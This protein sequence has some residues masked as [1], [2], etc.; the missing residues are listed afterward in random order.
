MALPAGAVPVLL[1]VRF[2]SVGFVLAWGQSPSLLPLVPVSACSLGTGGR[3]PPPCIRSLLATRRFPSLRGA[4]VRSCS[5]C[6][7]LLS[8][9]ARLACLARLVAPPPLA[10]RARAGGRSPPLGLLWCGGLGG[11]G[12]GLRCA[13]RVRAGL[14]A[15]VR[16]RGGRDVMVPGQGLSR[17]LPPFGGGLLVVRSLPPRGRSQVDQFACM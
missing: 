10:W 11:L 3:C 12:A 15:G 2:R 5:P 17:S 6:L 13:W 14:C 7:C 16:V 4:V 8:W 1:L 9:L